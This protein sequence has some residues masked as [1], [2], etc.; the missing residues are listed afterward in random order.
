M[1]LLKI[2][3]LRTDL[4]GVGAGLARLA[5]AHSL[6]YLPF[7]EF[8]SSLPVWMVFGLA[9]PLWR[10]FLRPCI[11]ENWPNPC[12]LWPCWGLAR[13][14]ICD[15]IYFLKFYQSMRIRH[16]LYSKCHF[17]RQMSVYDTILSKEL[18]DYFKLI[19]LWN[20]LICKMWFLRLNNVIYTHCSQ[21]TVLKWSCPAASP[22]IIRTNMLN[23]NGQGDAFWSL[24]H[25]DFKNVIF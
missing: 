11:S 21:K 5:I 19:I 10:S 2:M 3:D 22:Q 24:N 16:I 7:I 12:Q 8:L 13:K 25:L 6:Y 9:L 18:G 4:K 20:N 23:L 14:K 15:F 1:K 17:G